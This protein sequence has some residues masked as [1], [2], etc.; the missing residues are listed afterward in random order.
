VVIA[1]LT[2]HATGV[3]GRRWVSAE[4]SLNRQY[5]Q[6][7]RISAQYVARFLIHA[8]HD[9]SMKLFSSPRGCPERA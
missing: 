8:P 4:Q 3:Q 5:G 6:Q 1:S 7:V 2:P 9:P